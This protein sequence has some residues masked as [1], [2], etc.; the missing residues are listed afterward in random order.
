MSVL[1]EISIDILCNFTGIDFIYEQY[2]AQYSN[3]VFFMQQ[4]KMILLQL[5][6]EYETSSEISSSI[7]LEMHYDAIGNQ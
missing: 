6:E 3:D 5:L 7:K 4:K 2:T 1:I